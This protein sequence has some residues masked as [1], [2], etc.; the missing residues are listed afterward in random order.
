MAVA[1]NIDIKGC[2]QLAPIAENGISFCEKVC[3]ATRFM[4]YL[5][6]HTLKQVGSKPLLQSEFHANSNHQV[7]RSLCIVRKVL[8]RPIFILWFR[9]ALSY[10]WARTLSTFAARKKMTVYVIHLSYNSMT[11]CV[12]GCFLLLLSPCCSVPS[13]KA[14]HTSSRLAGCGFAPLAVMS[15]G[16]SSE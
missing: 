5:V 15:T 11:S 3:N 8:N 4:I 9:P 13:P 14:P 10:L 16:G 1:G 6:N 2:M 12:S 7:T